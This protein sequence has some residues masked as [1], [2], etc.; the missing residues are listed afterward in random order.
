MKFLHT[1]SKGGL[2]VAFLM[3]LGN[4]AFA[5]RAVK[6]KVTDADSG[7]GLIGATIQV[8]GTT[9]GTVTDIDGNYSLDV[10]AG[11]TQLRVS[12]TGY[13]ESTAPL[14]ASNMVD[15]AL[16]P[17]TELDELVV[18]G[19]GTLKTRE[20]TSSVVS[21]KAAEF[22][23]G[24]VNDAAALIQGKVA[25]LVIAR[26]GNDPNGSF[27]IRLR[28]LSTTSQNTSPLI[29]I[30]GVPAASLRQVDP[31]DIESI[32]V[33]KDGS[34]AAIYGTRA[35]SGVII[36]TT[37]RGQAGK[38][39]VEYSFNAGIDQVAKSVPVLSGAD[40]VKIGSGEDRG[41]NT[42]WFDEIS[43]NG[44]NMIHNLNLSG[45][46]NK[47]TYRASFNYRDV[48][49]IARKTGFQQYNA[50][51]ALQ[52][53]AL[54][55]RLTITGNMGATSRDA[56]VGFKDAFRYAT[57]Y[58]PTAPVTN[59]DGTYFQ[60]GGFDLFNPVSIVE[61][62]FNNDKIGNLFGNVKADLNIT[63][64]LTFSV[65]YN[66]TR[67]TKKHTEYYDRGGL[68]RS[69]GGTGISSQENKTNELF[70]STLNYDK[71]F[72]KVGFKGLLGYSWQ[73]FTEAAY[74][75]G[76]NGILLDELSIN[77]LGAFTTPYYGQNAP[78][79]YRIPDHRIIGFFGRAAFN[80]DDTYFLTA[81]LRREGSS[82][83]G[84]NNKWGLFPAVSGGVQLNKLI[85]G[86]TFDNLKL[87]AGYG[88]TGGIPKLGGLSIAKVAPLGQFYYDG[89]QYNQ[90]YGPVGTNPNPDLKWEKKADVNI[91][92]DWAI[93]D[94]KLSGSVEYYQTNT[95]DLLYAFNVPVP[96]NFKPITWLNVGELKNS[97][98]EVALNAN[99]LQKENA[100]WTSGLTFS[101]YKTQLVDLYQDF[102]SL[103][104]ANVGAPGLNGE[105]YTTIAKGEAIGNLVMRDYVGIN[106]AG[107][108]VFRDANGAETT[109]AGKAALIIAG[110]GL[111]KFDLGWSNTLSFGNFDAQ[112][113][114]RGVFGHSLANEYRVF[115][116]S[117]NA[118]TKT[119]N[120]VKTKYFNEKL[121]D[122]NTPSSFHV[123][124]A[125][126][127]RLENVTLGYNFKLPADSWFTKV[128]VYVNAQNPLVFTKYTG[129]DP[130]VRFSDPGAVDNG[131]REVSE[132]DANPLAPGIDRRSTYFRA[133]TFSVG[134]NFGF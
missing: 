62:G 114:L 37:K 28:G 51:I 119:W 125:D 105:Y 113:F 11:A 20:L 33:L 8:V 95:T 7:E 117:L 124:K 49:G 87:R 115:Y 103:Q 132:F 130:E 41:S 111:P 93:M 131:N 57:V 96:P 63:N 81:S 106:D 24:N 134:L 23:K 12:Y 100:T 79:S 58:N 39:S 98:V 112:V 69:Q 30:D 109:D 128:R 10:P 89:G 97:G 60:L 38:S 50:N 110:N 76:G 59:A 66:Q 26:P 91:G 102:K 18:V 67:D 46:S 104:I 47:T 68:Y 122:E 55:D 94:Y 99:L 2:L 31:N 90:A 127:V 32:D 80:Y 13:A 36:V 15:F 45:G 75:V 4:V 70:E 40:F 108:Y 71:G 19:Y 43:Q 65:F 120:K 5:Q 82:R 17:G 86:E 21:V 123:E 116:E 56:E 85:G 88:V 27:N 126:F 29:V 53:K 1:L 118:G 92:V 16:K 3:L 54:N 84:T 101:T 61:Q 64:G 35:S 9:R 22:N 72:G 83:F 129:V 42:N 44:T 14:G 48:N 52:Q 107:Q 6:G 78:Q 73:E 34:A 77:N 25:G 133:R 121:T 74:G